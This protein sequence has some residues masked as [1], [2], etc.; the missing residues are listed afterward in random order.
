MVF[1]RY[2]ILKYLELRGSHLQVGSFVGRLL[3]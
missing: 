1:G 3:P 2:L